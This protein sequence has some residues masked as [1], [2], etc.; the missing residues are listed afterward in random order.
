MN[1]N[2]I[3]SVNR[4]NSLPQ[5]QPA[6]RNTPPASSAISS[7]TDEVEISSAGKMMDNLSRTSSVR[8]E[9]IAQ[10]KAAIADGSYETPEKL[11]AAL[12]RLFDAH[13]LNG[14]D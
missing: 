9:R 8:E 13:G 7:P 3:G 10:I 5:V 1:V 6:V 2:G 4:T 12:G 14:S 11:E